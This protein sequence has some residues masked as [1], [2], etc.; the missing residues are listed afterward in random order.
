M[1]ATLSKQEA[2]E[3]ALGPAFQKEGQ[4]KE[5]K[6]SIFIAPGEHKPGAR[7]MKTI[8]DTLAAFMNAEGGILF[9]GVS[10]DYQPVGIE[11]DLKILEHSTSQVK[12]STPRLNDKDYTYKGTKD[13]Y[14]LKLRAL[15]RGFL[16]DNALP[17]IEQI[18]FH[19]V[20]GVWVC[21]VICKP[22]KPG[23]WVYSYDT[24]INDVTHKLE[25][26]VDIY[27]RY[28]NQKL[29]LKSEAR[30]AF[31][32][33]R[34]EMGIASQLEAFGSQSVTTI[35]DSVKEML[36]RLKGHH[37]TGAKVTVSGG[38]P[39]EKE[40]VS[41]AKKPKSL[42][43]DGAHYTD[44]SN[45]KDLVLKVLLKVQE[46]NPE[47]FDQMADDTT[48]AKQ[49]IRVKPRERHSDCFAEKFGTQGDIRIKSSLGNKTYLYREDYALRKILAFA[50]I[51]PTRFLFTAE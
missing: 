3:A 15:V 39:F 18:S 9:I 26:S 16:G 38:L 43:W 47:A 34:V 5:Y 2:F 46:L 11:N 35:V 1:A 12:V 22:C 4:R 33:D 44:V 24:R 51:N 37:I 14:E 31:I 40:P 42:A 17:L 21:R 30:D 13:G 50:N 10:D 27:V 29:L 49:V 28:G 19:Q 25:T 41:A 7:Q 23:D 20:S 32:R 6:T 45:W 8:A 48:F 36:T